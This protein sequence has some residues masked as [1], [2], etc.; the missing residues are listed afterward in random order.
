MNYELR[1]SNKKCNWNFFF[2]ERLG[3]DQKS[4]VQ[5]DRGSKLNKTA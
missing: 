2:K 4:V 1:A 3:S 5:R